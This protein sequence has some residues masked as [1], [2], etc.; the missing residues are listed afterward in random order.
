VRSP[1][2][3]MEP[4]NR[5]KKSPVRVLFRVLALLCGI[6]LIAWFVSKSNPAEIWH[7]LQRI[8]VRF[9]LLIFVTF[10]AYMMVVVGWIVSFP[11]KQEGLNIFN[12]FIIRLIGETLA[13]INPTNVI[14][15]ETLKAILLKRRGVAYHD[16]IVS[17]TISRI[18]IVLSAFTLILAGAIIF[19]DDLIRVSDNGSIPIT[20][21]A[22]FLLLVLTIGFIYYL[23]RSGRGILHVPI[24]L[25]EKISRVFTQSARITNIIEKM[26]LVDRELIEFYRT[27]KLMFLAAYLLSLFHWVVGA[28][29][30]YLIL[31]F[32]GIDISFLSCVA[33]EVG[34]MVFKALGSFVPGQVGIEEMANKMML[35]FVHVPSSSIWITVS[36]LRRA[37]QIFWILVGFVAFMILTRNTKELD[38]GSIVYNS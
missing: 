12:L 11:V 13:Q 1:S 33:V 18:S 7:Q 25:F 23:L 28:L 8:N 15:G 26:R 38:N 9:V 32:I 19:F 22:I 24:I 37:R 34:V 30:M 10:C 14:A 17:L 21:P 4:M 5:P 2:D 29:E 35:E 3:D 6:L 31:R 36:I 27:R 16:G 20:L